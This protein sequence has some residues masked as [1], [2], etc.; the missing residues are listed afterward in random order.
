MCSDNIFTI[1]V[2]DFIKLAKKHQKLQL[3]SL[4]YPNENSVTFQ[5][6]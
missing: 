3:F 6:L 2:W 1:I 5:K 4:I